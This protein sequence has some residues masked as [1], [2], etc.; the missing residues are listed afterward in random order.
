MKYNIIGRTKPFCSMCEMAKNLCNSEK[1]QY[2]YIELNDNVLNEFT[3][4]YPHL[5]RELPIVEV[6]DNGLKSYIGNFNDL[7][8]HFN[9]KRQSLTLN[10]ITDGFVL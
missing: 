6:D 1:V 4:K 9:E 5:K 3:L 7:K 2:N 10:E 8:L